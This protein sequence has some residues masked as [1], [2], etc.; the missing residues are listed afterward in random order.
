MQPFRARDLGPVLEP[1]E[2]GR[3]T[4]TWIYDETETAVRAEKDRD[5][6]A[7]PDVWFEYRQNR[8]AS[9]AEDTNGDGEP[10]LWE[11]YDEAEALVKRSKDLNYDG[12]PDLEEFADGS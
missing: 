5:G 10:D 4:L 12:R 7:R 2:D 8:L 9:V 3:F 1:D 6:N 11:E